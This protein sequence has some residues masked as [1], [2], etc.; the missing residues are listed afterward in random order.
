MKLS[1]AVAVQE[2]HLEDPGVMQT[3]IQ[4]G[5]GAPEHVL[6]L[7]EVERPSSGDDDVLLSG[8]SPQA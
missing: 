1:Q 8:Y 2:E 4:S 5:Y 3:V 7:C 6:T